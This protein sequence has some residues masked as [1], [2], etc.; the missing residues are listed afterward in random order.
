MC[1]WGAGEP[2][3]VN[4]AAR[5]QH[6]RAVSFW[7]LPFEVELALS[8]NRCL[9]SSQTPFVPSSDPLDTR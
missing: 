5:G 8:D 2:Y 7:A 9:F 1:S 4:C 6:R 3:G